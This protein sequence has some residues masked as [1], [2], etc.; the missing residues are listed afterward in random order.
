MSVM[1]EGYAA[2]ARQ[3]AGVEV[4]WEKDGAGNV[5]GICCVGY[6]RQDWD[7]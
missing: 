4:F 1:E 2:W 3:M 5:V 6:L 7:R